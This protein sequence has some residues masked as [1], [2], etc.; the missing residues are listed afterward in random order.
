MP[1]LLLFL[2]VLIVLVGGCAS[3][4]KLP[5]MHISSFSLFSS[6][7]YEEDIAKAYYEPLSKTTAAFVPNS[8]QIHLWREG[9]RVNVV[10]GLGMG[11]GSFSALA[12]ISL[13]A[14]GAI[15]ALDSAA[16]NLKKFNLD[17]KLLANW[18]LPNV[19][20]PQ[21]IA[22]GTEQNCYI[23]D[24]AAG[25]IIAYNLL[26]G[27]ESFRFGRFQIKRVDQLFANRDYLVAYDGESDSS[28]L[29]SSLGQFISYEAGQLLFDPY[30]NGIIISQDAIVSQ[31]SAAFLPL[32]AS[33]GLATIGKE[34]LVIVVDKHQVRLLKVDYEKL[35]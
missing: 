19:V 11:A 16:K 23:W 22:L 20:Q 30:N 18:S 9:K 7:S 14:D 34:V 28:A 3:A 12:D 6:V 4:P 27:S 29:F 17:G 33:T 13:G 26:D 2:L 25:E 8:H 24:A 15:Y 5:P 32:N 35:L 1:K 31:M 10:G 21:K